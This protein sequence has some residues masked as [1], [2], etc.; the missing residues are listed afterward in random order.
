MGWFIVDYMD[1]FGDA[2]GKD[3]N[4]RTAF[5]S[6]QVHGMCK[7]LE[8]AGLIIQSMNKS[9]IGAVGMEKLSGSGKLMYDADQIIFM[10]EDKEG[11]NI[12]RLVWDKMRE[13]D[14]D[15]F[16]RLVRRPGYP[17]FGEYAAEVRES[18]AE[19]YHKR[20]E[21]RDA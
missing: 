1:L 5:I 3:N 16:M 9:G 13:G 20:M 10:V 4:E 6:K 11:D 17:A 14:G 18:K 2:T 21:D 15:R 19:S 8:L 12:V 7:D